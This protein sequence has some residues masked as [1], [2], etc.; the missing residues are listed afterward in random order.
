[1]KKNKKYIHYIVHSHHERGVVGL[2][3]VTPPPWSP[4]IL[5]RG[6]GTWKTHSKYILKTGGREKEKGGQFYYRHCDPPPHIS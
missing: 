4:K 3:P 5:Q 2:K 6:G 1:M